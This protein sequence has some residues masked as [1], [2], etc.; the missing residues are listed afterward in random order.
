M[1]QLD[2]LTVGY[3]NTRGKVL[4]GI[5]IKAEAGSFICLLGRNGSG[6]STL[7]RTIAGLHPAL[8]GRALINNGDINSFRPFERARHISVVLTERLVSPGLT[9]SDVV[10]LGR[11]PYTDWHGRLSEADHA[12][13]KAALV[14]TG[15]EQFTH[16]LID[17][18]SDGERQRVMIARAFAQ[19]PALLVLDEITAFIDLPGRVEIMSTLRKHVHESGTIALLSSHDLE[20]SLRLADEVWLPDGQGGLATGKPGDIMRSGIIGKAFDSSDVRF[21]PEHGQFELIET[22]HP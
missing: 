2:N 4:A 10:S 13:I 5:N 14:A 12:C 9:V 1:L 21:S 22:R 7:L 11:L 3:S 16:R 18:L 15:I 6:K 8:E 17:D 19:R 20:L